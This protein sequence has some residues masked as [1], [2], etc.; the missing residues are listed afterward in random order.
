MINLL[1]LPP[2]CVPPASSQLRPAKLT[3]WRLRRQLGA[4]SL[5]LAADT[6]LAGS[7]SDFWSLPLHA[8]LVSNGLP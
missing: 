1:D 8:L 4:T 2:T 5:S 3:H 7:G 6:V